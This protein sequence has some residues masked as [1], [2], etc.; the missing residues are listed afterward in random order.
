MNSSLVNYL[1]R[2]LLAIAPDAWK[3]PLEYRF[4]KLK[5]G[6]EPETF[7]LPQLIERSGIA[8]D[9]GA[10]KGY[11]TYA[12]A[13]LPQIDRIEAFEPQPWCCESISAYAR[14]T[15]K[16]INVRTS[17]LSDTNSTLELNIPLLRGR[18][19]TTLS[20]G[21]ASFKKPD[22]EHQTVAVPV[23]RLDDCNLTKITFI[24][25]DVEGHEE[26]AIVGG[27]QTIIRE[28]PI[29]L[30]EIENRHLYDNQTGIKDVKG[31]VDLVESLGYA[32]YFLADRQLLPFAKINWVDSECGKFKMATYADRY[33]YNFI[34]KPV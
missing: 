26:S 27:K 12:L 20:V 23:C 13:Q 28:K 2:R 15:G 19:N 21:L 18:L 14:S 17:A 11:Y 10:N 3:L 16:N 31:I 24:K 1:F 8:I 33:I 34:F 29:L 22:V 5:G 4:L 7:Y 6:L 9:V 30:V 32:T 25:I